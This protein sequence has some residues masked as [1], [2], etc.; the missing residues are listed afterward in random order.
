MKI[1]KQILFIVPVFILLGTFL[2]PV[3]AENIS[4][5]KPQVVFTFD[6]GYISTYS[7]VLPILSARNI[8]GTSYI[9]TSW[10]GTTNFMTWDQINTLQNAYGWEIGSHS[11]SHPDLSTLPLSTLRTEVNGSISVL[12]ENGILVNS[13][14]SPYG[15]Y[16]NISLAEIRK[17]I[18]IHRGFWEREGEN[19]IPYDVSQPKVQSVENGVTIAQIKGWIDSA[20]S[21]GTTLVL[22]FHEVL[23]NLDPND[24]YVTT[25]SDLTAVA[26]YVVQKQITPV[27]MRTGLAMTSSNLIN[28]GNF[29]V[30][31]FGNGWDRDYTDTVTYDTLNFGSFPSSKTSIR[32]KGST[33][34]ASHVYAPIVSVTDYTNTYGVSAFVNTDYLSKGEFGFFVDEYNAQGVWI[35]GVWLGKTLRNSVDNYTARYKPSSAAV[36]SVRLQ[37][38]LTKGSNGRVYVDDVSM[39]V[40]DSIEP[41]PTITPTP[42]ISVIPS[43]NPSITPSVTISPSP[44]P[45]IVPTPTTTPLP[46][47]S[48][49]PSPTPT[50][51]P[52]IV[53]LLA[54]GNFEVVNGSNWVAP[55]TY[56]GAGV[57]AAIH[58][59]NGTRSVLFT[60]TGSAH[61]LF[62]ESIN[63]TSGITYR[64]QTSVYA[65]TLANEFGFYIDEYDANGNWISGQWKGAIYGNANSTISYTYVPTSTNVRKVGLQYYYIGNSTG[66]VY[67][68]NVVFGVNP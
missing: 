53:N 17:V 52:T 47:P 35:S 4:S 3:S 30:I 63:V 40:I 56:S 24:P 22:V 65:Q 25:I 16:D 7:N 67:I 66:S 27:T 64:W 48:L 41:T 6:D 61:H 44:T 28:N 19:Q 2:Q 59:V 15:S 11:V 13:L 68:D 5:K 21:N 31:P 12:N 8:P 60:P 23:P 20:V 57:S 55:W 42:T 14:A 9:V 38:Y 46:T 36:S 33:A 32:F 49:I 26:D 62:S 39:R 50:P 10:V 58:P 34:H 37:M 1:I 51:P 29:D 54:N 18:P 43:I 45:T